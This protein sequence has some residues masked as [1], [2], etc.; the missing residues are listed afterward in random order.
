MK[1]AL[2]LILTATLSLPAFAKDA[3]TVTKTGY[4]HVT[5]V[6]DRFSGVSTVILEERF[7]SQLNGVHLAASESDG[8]I[9]LMLHIVSDQGWAA[10]NGLQVPTLVDGKPLGALAFTPATQNASVNTWNKKAETE[11]ILTAPISAA[12]LHLLTTAKT[13]EFKFG[14]TGV[15]L[16]PGQLEYLKEFEDYLTTQHLIQ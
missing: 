4:K 8:H 2:L 5:V 12:G 10:L 14:Q 15:S 11:E 16:A 1:R 3:Q 9:Y 6:T 13:V 7:I